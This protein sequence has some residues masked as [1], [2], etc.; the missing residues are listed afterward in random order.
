MSIKC[1]A[2]QALKDDLSIEQ[3]RIQHAKKP[4]NARRLKAGAVSEEERIKWQ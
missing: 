4:A 3:T 1:R 2:L